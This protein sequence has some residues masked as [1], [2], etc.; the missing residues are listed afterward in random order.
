M[1]LARKRLKLV[2]EAAR[3]HLAQFEDPNGA[4][5]PDGFAVS[6]DAA[7]ALR[8]LLRLAGAKL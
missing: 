2:I 3:A 4:M 7:D 5:S 1:I 6:A 8:E